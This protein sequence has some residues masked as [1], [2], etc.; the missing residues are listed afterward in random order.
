MTSRILQAALHVSKRSANEDRK[1]DVDSNNTHGPRVK[2]VAPDF[3][4]KMAPPMVE[5]DVKNEQEHTSSVQANATTVSSNAGRVPVSSQTKIVST[6]KVG[7]DGKKGDRASEPMELSKTCRMPFDKAST[8]IMHMYRAEIG[9]LTIYRTRLDRTTSWALTLL[10]ILLSVLFTTS[11]GT[12][13]AP[14]LFVVLLAFC[15]LEGRRYRIFLATHDRC[16][17]LET[18]F[19]AEIIGLEYEKDWVNR[20]H[21]SL[22]DEGFTTTKITA[23]CNRFYRSYNIMVLIVILGWIIRIETDDDIHWKDEAVQFGITTSVAGFLTIFTYFY[24]G[25]QVYT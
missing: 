24:R 7:G 4:P 17:I 8:M 1:P 6:A 16:R 15:Y 25:E 20:L 12:A 2:E 5:S 21:S 11:G 13:V 18:G 22:L 3:K 10:T 9:K 19:Y 14:L 23:F